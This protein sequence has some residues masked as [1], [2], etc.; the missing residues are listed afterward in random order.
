MRDSSVKLLS[1]FHAK[2]FSLTGGRLGSRLVDNDMLLLTTVGAV[3]G[4]PHTVPLLFLQQED[5]LVV[6]ASYGG[7][8]QHPQ[9]YRNLLADPEVVVQTPDGTSTYIARTADEDERR[10]WWP[11]IVEAYDGYAVY[12]A[13][14]DREIP[15]VILDPS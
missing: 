14:T 4:L 12:A 10:A 9:W 6:I 2:L 3:S 13:R 5:S 8:P 15:V 11:K 7:R 1:A